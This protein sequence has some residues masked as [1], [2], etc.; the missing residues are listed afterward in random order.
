MPRGRPENVPEKRPNVL[1]T[2][3]YGP[4][5]NA[6][7]RIRSGTSFGPTQDVKLSI[8]YKMVFYVIFC[9]FRDSNELYIR[10]CTR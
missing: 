7:G 8:I 2:S 6:K 9:I 4:I 1:R 10:H 3:Q 5:C